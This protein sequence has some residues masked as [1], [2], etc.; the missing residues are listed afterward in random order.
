MENFSYQERSLEKD[1]QEFIKT[2]NSVSIEE[3]S[4]V[5]AEEARSQLV[6]RLEQTKLF[7]LGEV[8]GVKENVDIIYTLFK[9]FNF[10]QLALEWESELQVVVEKY[11][12]TGEVDFDAIQNSADGRI[13][14]EHFALFNKLKNEG[15]LEKVICFDSSGAVDWDTRDENMAQNIL[16]E[17]SDALTLV[18]A[19]N[20]H[21][22]VE[23]ITLTDE[24]GEHQPMGERIKA[25]VP[26]VPYGNI[27]YQSG[28]HHNFGPQDFFAD[29]APEN[30][31]AKFYRTEAEEYTFVLPAAQAAVVPNPSEQ[32]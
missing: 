6:D 13:T 30:T 14:A 31:E 2:I 21:A 28:Q 19:G 16:S 4:A 24:P 8:H 7:I 32:L 20:L 26:S 22:R 10:R 29:S 5:F 9:K 25:Q 27:A 15:R 1:R 18:V 3:I 11:L 23:S 12:E 17:L